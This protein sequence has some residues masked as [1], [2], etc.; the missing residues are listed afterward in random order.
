M[1]EAKYIEI[2]REIGDCI[3]K[4]RWK[5]KL[6]GVAKL[7]KEF[8]VSPMTAYKA[9]KVLSEQGIVTIHGASGTYIAK[10][11]LRRPRYMNI[12]VVGM[13]RRQGHSSE[14]S[15]MEDVLGQRGY[16]LV[17]IGRNHSND[18]LFSMRC[19]EN[20]PFDGLV[21]SNSTLSTEVIVNLRRA[22]MPFISMNRISDVPGV[23]WVDFDTEKGMEMALQHLLQQGHRRIAYLSFCAALAEHEQ[24]NRDVY[25]RVLSGAGAYDPELYMVSESYQ[26]YLDEHGE[27]AMEFGGR[28]LARRAM[29]LLDPPTA[30][31]VPVARQICHIRKEL[32]KMGLS[33]AEQFMLVG[34]TTLEE[35]AEM[36]S[37]MPALVYDS[38]K[39]AVRVMNL[40]MDRLQGKATGPVQELI[41]PEMRV[42]S[43]CSQRKAV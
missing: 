20:L 7:H 43:D 40:L 36:V 15:A 13:L 18:D 42:F 39:R 19:L 11:E 32:E 28:Q 8:G 30:A 4:G 27:E 21:F 25:Q 9:I 2:S 35:Q 16:H 33:K 14:L 38:Q 24:R 31:F 12:G 3:A 1:I 10:T 23:D 17:T 34:L 5:D 37:G 22:N 6:P 29:A 41:A 26:H